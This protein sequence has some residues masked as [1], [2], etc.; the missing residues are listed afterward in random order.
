MTDALLAGLE[1]GAHTLGLNLQ[2]EQSARLLF[3]AHQTT[4]SVACQ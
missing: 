3:Q 2:P 1:A 4:L